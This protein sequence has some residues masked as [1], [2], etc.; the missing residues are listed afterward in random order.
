MGRRLKQ[1]ASSVLHALNRRFPGA[2]KLMPRGLHRWVLLRVLGVGDGYAEMLQRNP[3]RLFLGHELMPWVAAQYRRV[4]F[5]GTAP[6]TYQF[7]RLFAAEPDRYET[8]DRTPAVRVWGARIHH[9][10]D[11]LDIGRLVPAGHYDCIVLNGVIAYRLPEIA[12][13]GVETRRFGDLAAALAGVLR[14]G[15]L[16]IVGW[17]GRDLATSPFPDFQPLFERGA[18]P[19]GERKA[20]EG[21]PHVLEFYARRPAP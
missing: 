10:A 19:W 16:L 14:P 15:G 12:D 2:K 17:N 13:Y 7:E 21:D 18:T 11:I 1:A 9:V 6:Y 8:I 4:L 20:F 3:E 5:V